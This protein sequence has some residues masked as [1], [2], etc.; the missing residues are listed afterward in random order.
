MPM[1]E[2]IA[3][4]RPKPNARVAVFWSFIEGAEGGVYYD[5]HLI[6]NL[7]HF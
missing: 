5:T 4:L 3:L 2:L 7:M 1:A 6:T